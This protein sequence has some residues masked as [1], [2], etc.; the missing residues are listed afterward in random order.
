MSI[1]NLKQFLLSSVIAVLPIVDVRAELSED[2]QQQFQTPPREAQPW[3]YWV[4]TG[5]TTRAA[6]TRDLQEMKAKGIA[7]CIL[8]ECQ[9]SRG[10]NWWNRTLALTNKDYTTVPTTDYPNPYYTPI[11]SGKYVTWAAHWRELVRFAAKECAR[12]GIS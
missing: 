10:V 8:Y 2:L 5:D 12:L 9:S 6:M 7:G 3:V 4:L 11:P 1:I